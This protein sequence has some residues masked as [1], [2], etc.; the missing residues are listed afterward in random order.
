MIDSDHT[1][2]KITLKES[3]GTSESADIP[4]KPMVDISVPLVDLNNENFVQNN[5]PISIK[6][7]YKPNYIPELRASISI[8]SQ[9]KEALIQE[10]KR[11]QM[12][13]VKPSEIALLKAQTQY[14]NSENTNNQIQDLMSKYIEMTRGISSLKSRY[15]IL[16]KQ[17]AYQEVLRSELTQDINTLDKLYDTENWGNSINARLTEFDTSTIFKKIDIQKLTD[18]IAYFHKQIQTIHQTKDYEKASTAFDEILKSAKSQSNFNLLGTKEIKDEINQLKSTLEESEVQLSRVAKAVDNYKK[19]VKQAEESRYI[20]EKK[21]A[22]NYQKQ[23]DNFKTKDIKKN[24]KI[25]TLRSQIEKMQ[26]ENLLI[27]REIDRLSSL[28]KPKLFQ[29]NEELH[30]IDNSEDSENEDA[31]DDFA[32]I[33]A[34]ERL[35]YTLNQQVIQLKMEINDLNHQYSM[36]KSNILNNQKRR[37]KEIDELQGTLQGNYVEIEK[38][39]MAK[40][41]KLNKEDSRDLNIIHSLF[42]NIS[43][44]IEG[45][46]ASFFRDAI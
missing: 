6:Q 7:Q 32:I 41:L 15:R 36:L 8:L 35:K 40:K 29:E 30:T 45:I 23:I 3:S 20:E 1:K 26:S 4:Q 16:E 14:Y 39:M 34:N 44:S 2:T 19:R 17:I 13:T 12:H 42:K 33:Q 43:G 24:N 27:N 46:Q 28:P 11:V 5:H 21:A 25:S 38:T 18:K 31:N 9:R 22:E 37:L 10:Y